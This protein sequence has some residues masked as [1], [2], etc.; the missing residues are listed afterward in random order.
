MEPP[1]FVETLSVVAGDFRVRMVNVVVFDAASEIGERP[2]DQ[3]ERASFERTL[4]HV[5]PLFD[6][7]RRVERVLV[8]K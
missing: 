5:P 7:V 8:E 2:R 6:Y 3:N 4:S 1:F